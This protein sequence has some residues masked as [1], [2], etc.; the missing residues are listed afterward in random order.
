M[1]LRL[2]GQTLD[3]D[4]TA[5]GSLISAQVP[6][7][8]DSVEGSDKCDD[9]DDDEDEDEDEDDEEYKEED[10]NNDEDVEDAHLAAATLDIDKDEE[11]ENVGRDHGGLHSWQHY[12]CNGSGL[13]LGSGLGKVNILIII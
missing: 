1:D 2:T 12:H 8:N 6:G 10:N 7:E 3:M 5:C 11:G 13:R 9:E 4:S